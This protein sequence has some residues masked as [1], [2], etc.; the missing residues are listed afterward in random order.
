MFS[1]KLD[2]DKKDDEEDTEES[3]PPA[4]AIGGGRN[5]AL[6]SMMT[7]DEK[8][9]YM[10]LLNRGR[11]KS[12]DS[13]LSKEPVVYRSISVVDTY[14]NASQSWRDSVPNSVKLSKSY[15]AFSK[16]EPV[17]Q[18]VEDYQEF[19]KSYKPVSSKRSSQDEG[20]VF[21]WFSVASTKSVKFSVLPD[22]PPIMELQS[23]WFFH[24]SDVAQPVRKLLSSLETIRSKKLFH[25][26]FAL[27]SND[28]ILSNAKLGSLFVSG[29]VCSMSASN[30]VVSS[31]FFEFHIFAGKLETLYPGSGCL[32][33]FQAREGDKLLLHE[34]HL[35]VEHQM[36][37]QVDFYHFDSTGKAYMK[38]PP[39]AL[40]A[41][42]PKSPVRRL[43]Q[44]MS[45]S[46][47][48]EVLLSCLEHKGSCLLASEQLERIAKITSDESLDPFDVFFDEDFKVNEALLGLYDFLLDG[49]EEAFSMLQPSG[50]QNI[51]IVSFVELLCTIMCNLSS[52]KPIRDSLLDPPI[53]WTLVKMLRACSTMMHKDDSE[54]SKISELV[55]LHFANVA[56]SHSSRLRAVLMDNDVKSCLKEAAAASSASTFSCVDYLLNLSC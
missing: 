26:Q 15:S 50:C 19:L 8:S 7:N 6:A 2:R 43:S 22:A 36:R 37:L 9:L 46:D 27:K 13:M 54:V 49:F 40:L 33:E 51:T 55:F 38:Q 30:V 45:Q 32:L 31:S 44:S 47:P 5:A 25:L 16:T 21:S 29:S 42:R 35:A 4:S 11:T 41:A 24:C 1:S 23:T 20:T 18:E 10:A 53:V 34:L 52:I 56:E 39:L 17:I 28:K 3:E 48:V 12:I 14:T